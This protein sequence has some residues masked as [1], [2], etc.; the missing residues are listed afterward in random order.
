[1]MK[2][3]DQSFVVIANHWPSRSAGQFESEPYRIIAAETLSYWMERIAEI[4][5]KNTPVLS[6]G[7]FNDEPFDR[8]MTNYALSTSSRLKVS[9]SRSPRLYNPM[10]YFTGE[11]IGTH[12]FNNF[13]TLL[14]Q[15]LI[16][17]PLLT[18]AGGIKPVSGP[19]GR[20]TDTEIFRHPEMMSSGRYKSPIRFGRPSSGLN[21]AGFSDHYPITIRLKTT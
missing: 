7:D 4:M 14:D 6:M 12:Y 2:H 20:I 16:N 19:E 9:Y 3:N 10:H 21:T 13:P 11:G 5:G 17:K 15:F 1:M 8:S 18:G